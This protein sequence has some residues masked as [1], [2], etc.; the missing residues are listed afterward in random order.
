MDLSKAVEGY[1]I[2]R[3]ADGYSSTT[4]AMY[5]WA[6]DLLA[7]F[8]T[9]KPVENISQADLQGFFAWLR[10]DYQPT[11]MNGDQSPLSGRSLENIWTAMRSFFNWCQAELG[12]IARPDYIIQRPRYKPAVVQPFTQDE[13]RRLLSVCE[14]SGLANTDRRAQFTMPR[15]TAARDTALISTLLDTGIRVSECA[16]LRVQDVDLATGEVT[17]TPWGSGLKTKGRHVYLGKSA[18]KALWRYLSGKDDP[19]PGDRLFLTD[20]GR[21]MDRNSIRQL[22]GRLG[23]RAGING[24]HPHRFRH[25]FAIEFLRNGGD[26]FALQ[27]LLGHSTLDMV[28]LYL[29]L[30]DS[31]VQAA[32]RKSSPLDRWQI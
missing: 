29:A 17:I 21:P 1:M 2:A 12:L 32:L 13:I 26:V 8:L 22:L 31:D 4:L 27:R 16:R 20:E 6:L 25:T 10:S 5:R 19:A 23:A 3:S 28:K 14:R 18:R 30:A 15:P 11:R 24:C 7:A 9:E